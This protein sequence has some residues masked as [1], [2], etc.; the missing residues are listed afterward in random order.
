MLSSQLNNIDHYAG[1]RLMP[2]LNKLLYNA[3]YFSTGFIKPIL[4]YLD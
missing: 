4:R 3:S 1:V 2:P